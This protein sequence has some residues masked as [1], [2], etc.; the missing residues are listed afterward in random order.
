MIKN[1]FKIAWR[2]ILKNKGYSAINILGLAIG[3]AACVIIMVFVFYERSFDRIHTQ[4]IYRLNEVQK[5]E[6]MVAPQ[7]V[8]LSMYPMAPT[9]KQDFP[10]VLNFTRLVNAENEN[11]VAG[12]NRVVLSNLFFVDTTFLQIFDFSLL[13]GNRVTVLQKPNSLLLTEESAAKLFG[14][15]DPIGKTVRR[16]SDD[17]LSF[18][19]TGRASSSSSTS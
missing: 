16:F 6:G 12:E 11:L 5:Y 9:L 1:Y 10:E 18:I 14:K 19:V 4:N 2:N 13:K 15:N 17:T 7:N 3:M 8:A